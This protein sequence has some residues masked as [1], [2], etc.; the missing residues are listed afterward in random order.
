[1]VFSFPVKAPK[2]AVCTEDLDVEKQLDLWEVYQD[3]WCEHKPSVTVYYSDDEFLAAGQ[4]I[5][6]K[7]DK[8]SGVSF[9]PRSDH[10]YQQAPYEEISKEEYTKMTKAMPKIII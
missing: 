7:L 8:C 2:D 1:V 3:S 4:W 9:L 10:V 5:W 6:D